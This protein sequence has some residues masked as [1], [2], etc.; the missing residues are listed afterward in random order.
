MNFLDMLDPQKRKALELLQMQ[1]MQQQFTP[2]MLQ[3]GMPQGM[4][5]LQNMPMPMQQGQAGYGVL[6][7]GANTAM[8]QA[9]AGGAPSFGQAAMGAL[10][11]L[12]ALAGGG[13]GGGQPEVPP[14]PPPHPGRPVGTSKDGI[15]RMGNAFAQ[16]KRRRPVRGLLGDA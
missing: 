1:Q 7:P 13:A 9:A 5:A 12:L 2:Q 10:P 14:P 6:A 15:P 8:N 16:V 11:G 3:Q 4:G